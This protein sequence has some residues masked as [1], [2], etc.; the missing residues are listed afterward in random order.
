MKCVDRAV[1]RVISRAH[2]I[3]RYISPNH[4]RRQYSMNGRDLA[5]SRARI[6]NTSECKL[7]QLRSAQLLMGFRIAT[8]YSTIDN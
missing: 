7:L 8:V 1:L 6:I 4:A 3:S 5:K 2:A